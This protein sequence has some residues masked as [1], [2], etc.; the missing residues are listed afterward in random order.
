MKFTT[1]IHAVSWQQLSRLSS[2]KRRISEHVASFIF[3]A[4]C[5]R[6]GVI[7]LIETIRALLHILY[8]QSFCHAE[9][10]DMAKNFVQILRRFI[11]IF[12]SAGKYL[13][14]EFKN[15]SWFPD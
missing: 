15:F 4:P 5:V 9:R 12:A 1:P 6:Y 14:N 11:N 2:Q 3:P 8:L 13:V 7:P 10:K